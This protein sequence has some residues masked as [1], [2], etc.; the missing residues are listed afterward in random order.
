MS[1]PRTGTTEVVTPNSERVWLGWLIAV[2]CSFGA[3]ESTLPVKL[4]A[5]IRKHLRIHPQR[6]GHRVL[7]AAL[8]LGLAWFAAHLLDEQEE[9]QWRR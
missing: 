2:V 3:L 8:L 5:V 7:G 4:C 1:N 9:T 6:P